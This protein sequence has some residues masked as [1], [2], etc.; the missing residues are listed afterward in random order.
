MS[1]G[2]LAVLLYRGLWTQGPFTEAT[3]LHSRRAWTAH[4][5]FGKLFLICPLTEISTFT[6]SKLMGK[7]K[8]ESDL[9]CA[10]DGHFDGSGA[11]S[12]DQDSDFSP[13][14]RPSKKRSFVPTKKTTKR[15]AAPSNGSNNVTGASGLNHLS[16]L[17]NLAQPGPMRA[18]LL[19][20]YSGVHA[21][22]GMP[23]RKPY[24]SSLGPE[25]RAQRA[26]EV[27]QI[28]GIG[29]FVNPGAFAR[30]GFPR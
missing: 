25:D 11:D 12:G 17:H 21:S 19:R 20:W 1:D 4:G 28:L 26:Y 13:E 5:N 14:T 9:D 10:S 16:S 29:L 23:W 30:S 2:P 6:Y 24:D 3:D 15:A 22:R 27:G 8:A 18:A 7:R